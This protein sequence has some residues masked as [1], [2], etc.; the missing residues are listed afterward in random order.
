MI[1]VITTLNIKTGG[2]AAFEAAMQPIM[3]KVRSEPGNK[4]C[5]LY[6]T[7]G[8]EAYLLFERFDNDGALATHRAAPHF[9]ELRRMLV[10]HLASRPDTQVIQEVL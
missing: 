1:G 4:L 9:Q 3:A 6:K 7:G 2:N 10:D 8:S 5:A